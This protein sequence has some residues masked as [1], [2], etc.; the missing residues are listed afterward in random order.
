MGACATAEGR[1][2]Q[3]RATKK[4]KQIVTGIY[5]SVFRAFMNNYEIRQFF[6]EFFSLRLRTVEL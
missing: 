1:K 4:R 5:L 6:I 2:R 3:P